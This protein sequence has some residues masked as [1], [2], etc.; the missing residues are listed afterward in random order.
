MSEC[1]QTVGVLKSKQAPKK[2]GLRLGKNQAAFGEGRTA[3]AVL[4]AVSFRF[5]RKAAWVPG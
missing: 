4:C 2:G 5:T 1:R 3:K